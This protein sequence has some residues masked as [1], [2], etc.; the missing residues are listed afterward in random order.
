MDYQK[1]I[2]IEPGKRGRKLC[3]RGLRMTVYDVLEYLASS[4][5]HEETL[6]DF[7]DLKQEDF[8]PDSPLPPTGSVDSS[9][10]L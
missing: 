5:T 8:K 9:Q 3:I 10:P 7:P 4:M 2:T 6:R 1:L